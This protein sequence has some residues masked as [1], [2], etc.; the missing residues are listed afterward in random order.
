MTFDPMM[1]ECTGLVLRQSISL[2]LGQFTISL[3]TSYRNMTLCSPP[4]KYLNA[5]SN[6]CTSYQ[7]KREGK[8]DKK[9]DFKSTYCLRLYMSIHSLHGC[10][11]QSQYL[12]ALPT[13]WWNEF[14]TEVRTTESMGIFRLY[15]VFIPILTLLSYVMQLF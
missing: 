12:S 6:A 5:P 11:S 4:E 14:P 10:L 7:I 8:T 13:Q 2:K 3:E 1:R 9:T 15:Y